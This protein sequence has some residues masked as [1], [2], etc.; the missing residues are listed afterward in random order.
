[1]SGVSGYQAA[2][3]ATNANAKFLQSCHVKFKAE[4]PSC[5]ATMRE[6]FRGAFS[7]ALRAYSG[8]GP[9]PKKAHEP[10]QFADL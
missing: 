7:G 8:P 3:L 1:M 5:Q 6:E 9:S 10:T 4:E 2:R